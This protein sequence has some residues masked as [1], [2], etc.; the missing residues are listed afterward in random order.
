MKSARETDNFPYQMSTVCYFIVDKKGKVSQIP[1]KNKSDK[2]RVLEAYKTVL[3][4]NAQIYAVW[5]G[6]WRSDLFIIDDLDIFAKE[7]ELI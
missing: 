7:L 5:P 6:N 3:D 4:G 1:H 2:P